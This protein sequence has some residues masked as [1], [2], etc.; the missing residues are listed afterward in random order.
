MGHH[1]D[2][3]IGSLGAVSDQAKPNYE[4]PISVNRTWV[5][6]RLILVADVFWI[7]WVILGSHGYLSIDQWNVAKV[8][9][10]APARFTVKVVGFTSLTQ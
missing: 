1:R 3:L 10:A 7:D 9:L 5:K 8:G 4:N 2:R 6:S